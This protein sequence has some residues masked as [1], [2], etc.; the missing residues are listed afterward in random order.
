MAMHHTAWNEE[1]TESHGMEH[2]PEQLYDLQSQH[3]LSEWVDYQN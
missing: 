3:V 2:I 1:Q